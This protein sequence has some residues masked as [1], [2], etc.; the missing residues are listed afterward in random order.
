MHT[1]F[2]QNDLHP[3]L[4]QATQRYHHSGIQVY[5]PCTDHDDEEVKEFYEHIEN[6]IKKVP[7]KD[8]LKILGDWNAK[9]DPDA[10]SDWRGT[11]GQF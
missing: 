5:A 3:N 8:I 2:Q 4:C 1:S 9:V 11:V 10:N 7:K 6:Q